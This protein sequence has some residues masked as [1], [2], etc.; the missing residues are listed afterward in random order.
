MNDYYY[1]FHADKTNFFALDN[2][3][4]QAG[5]EIAN[6]LLINGILKAGGPGTVIGF[7][8][9]TMAKTEELNVA[10]TENHSGGYSALIPATGQVISDAYLG[11]LIYNAIA[12]TAIGMGATAGF[13]LTV[14]AIAGSAFIVTV[15]NN[16]LANPWRQIITEILDRWVNDDLN[17]VFADQA[18][19]FLNTLDGIMGTPSD[20]TPISDLIAD[21]ADLFG[22][23]FTSPIVLDLN[24]N[25]FEL[26]RAAD[27]VHFDI[28]ADGFAEKTGWVKPADAF[29][30]RDLNGNGVIDSQKEMFGND[31]ASTAAAKLAA[32]D[33]NKDG[34][35]S[36]ADSGWAALRLWKDANGDGVSQAD[37]LYTLAS[38]GVGKLGVAHTTETDKTIAGNVVDWQANWYTTGGALGGKYG[39]VLF[40]TNDEDSWYVG[41][42][43]TALQSFNPEAL[44]LP[45]SRGYGVVKSLH[46]AASES[47]GVMT[48][49]KAVDSLALSGLSSASQKVAD[50]LF[51]W[52]GVS[53]VSAQS[54]GQYYN[55]QTIAF[56]EKL[57]DHDWVVA[58][59]VGTIGSQFPQT[60]ISTSELSEEFGMAWQVLKTRLMAQGPLEP[61]FTNAVYDF[62]QDTLV[63]NDSLS[64]ILARAKT[65]KPTS[66][67]TEYW[68]EVGLVLMVQADQ[69][70]GN[71]A[72]IQSALNAAAGFSVAVMENWLKGQTGAERFE[73]SKFADYIDLLGGNDTVDA[74]AGNDSVLGGSGND[75]LIGGSDNDTLVGGTGNDYLQG[76]GGNDTYRYTKG[77]GNDT[78]FESGSGNDQIIIS[79]YSAA[80]TV[81][82][83]VGNTTDLQIT[84]S[85]TTSDKIL[86]EDAL[87]VGTDTMETITIGTTSR[88][89]DSIRNEVLTK[90]ATSGNNTINGFDG[91]ANSIVGLAGNDKLTGGDIAD[92]LKGD[93]GNDTLKGDA[94]ND[95]LYGGNGT[96][97]LDGGYGN[98]VLYGDAGNDKLDGGAGVD[99]LTGGAGA[100]IFLFGKLSSEL[101]VGA[102]ADRVSGFSR[103]EGDKIELDGFGFSASNFIGNMASTSFTSGGSKQF[104]YQKLTDGAGKYTLIRIDFVDDG[105]SD[106]EIRLDGIHLDLQASDFLF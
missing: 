15:A 37:E 88:T 21:A 6:D 106:R 35:V 55:Q 101:G 7:E 31:A 65:L 16:E 51:A 83:R 105:V 57:F 19:S 18:N 23:A 11:T 67:V 40:E 78:I 80:S 28:D 36:S 56:M 63:L 97:S 87:E 73:G 22:R 45:L 100:D 32:L 43:T 94:G 12:I 104:G 53:G 72:A 34:F 103:G 61:V 69:L 5:T 48:K 74:G 17:G 68:Q 29:L 38:Q 20:P 14:A 93:D 64:A 33:T 98:D 85:G 89:I 4:R 47:A 3:L 42:D 86:V 50:L 54:G 95:T 102:S 58:G 10:I 24:N 26:L 82:T 70:G 60:Y 81:F 59:G 44:L 91:R 84:F 92:T 46:L 41:S 77:D 96:D 75:S 2:F 27:G 62:S 99:T 79:G 49:L 71:K 39:D 13:P 1:G 30:V 52:A 8:F 25:G 90:Q 9:W 66:G 76:D